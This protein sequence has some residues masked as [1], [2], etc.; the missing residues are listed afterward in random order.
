MSNRDIAFKVLEKV[1]LEKQF[2]SVILRDVHTNPVD[3]RFITALVYTTIQNDRFLAYQYEEFLSRQPSK[4]TELILKMSIAQLFMMDRIPE[5]AAVNEAVALTKRLKGLKESK[6]VNAVL[7]Q[8]LRRGFRTC[9]VV[10]LESASVR[11]SMPLWLLKLFSKHYSQ[12]FAID[13]AQQ[14]LTNAPTYLRINPASVL[15]D[16]IR[17]SEWIHEENGYLLADA[18]VFQEPW[19]EQ[20][21]IL[22][23][24]KASQKVVESISLEPFQTVLDC[25]CAPGTK[26]MQM[27]DAM[28]RTGSIVAVEL[29]PRRAQLV[30]QLAK[31]WG[32]NTVD[33]IVSD[34]LDFQ[35]AGEF[36]VVVVDAPCSGLG[37]IRHKPDIKLNIKPDDLDALAETQARILHHVA[38]YVKSQG[39]LVYST[40]TLN[41]KEN[42]VQIQRFLA[43][44]PEFSLIS[45]QVIDPVLENCDGFYIA[46]C[47]RT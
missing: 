35:T 8:V 34:V 46:K 47:L 6:F 32:V 43:S 26:A 24:D 25:C 27:A 31:R 40:C 30:E 19:L 1:Y 22:I 23:Q 3:Q 13:Y 37:V 39:L 20:G 12:E 10:D 14:C 44:H 15:H 38:H 5:Y 36:D 7:N 42:Q 9:E 4:Q 21:D 33:V 11:Y 2:P 29:M 18:A 28:Q 45:E 41:K 16:H 17:E